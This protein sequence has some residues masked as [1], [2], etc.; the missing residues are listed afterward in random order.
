MIRVKNIEKRT[1]YK[2]LKISKLDRLTKLV[3]VL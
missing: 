3:G 2:I 1:I